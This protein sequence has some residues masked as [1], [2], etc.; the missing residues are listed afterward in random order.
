MK[1]NELEM[2]LGD[3][4]SHTGGIMSTFSDP[5]LSIDHSSI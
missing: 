1:Q 5:K 3:S 2:M 4:T